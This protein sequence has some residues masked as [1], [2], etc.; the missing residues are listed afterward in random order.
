LEYFN[1]NF[2]ADQFKVLAQAG[3]NI[4]DLVQWKH[5][6]NLGGI[7]VWISCWAEN[8]QYFWNEAR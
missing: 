3:P 4:G 5:N 7:G 2:T 8:L 1:N 6:Q